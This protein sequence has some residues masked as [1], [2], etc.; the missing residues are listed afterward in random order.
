[1]KL[2]A[3]FFQVIRWAHMMSKEVETTIWRTEPDPNS[4]NG[5]GVVIY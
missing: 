3:D 1:M 2:K 5:K 4:S